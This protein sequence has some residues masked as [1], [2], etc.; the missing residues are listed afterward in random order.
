MQV[1]ATQSKLERYAVWTGEN[2][3]FV[4]PRVM[5]DRCGNLRD[6]RT[7]LIILE[8]KYFPDSL[9]SYAVIK[10]LFSIESGVMLVGCRLAVCQSFLVQ[11]LSMIA[12]SIIPMYLIT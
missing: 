10:V 6:Q 5:E 7:S 2:R 12:N 11:A 1:L 8:I 4:S 3:V 9:A